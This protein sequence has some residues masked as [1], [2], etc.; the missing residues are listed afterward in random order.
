MNSFQLLV[1][2]FTTLVL[3]YASNNEVSAAPDPCFLKDYKYKDVETTTGKPTEAPA[4]PELIEKF[5]RL[6]EKKMSQL[7]QLMR[8]WRK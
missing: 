1:T 7:E 6:K 2:V 4:V 8:D 5:D 3:I